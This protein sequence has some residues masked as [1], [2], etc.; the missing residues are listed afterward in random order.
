VVLSTQTEFI[1]SLFVLLAIALLAG[2]VAM[3]LGQVALVGQLIAGVVLGPY[4][5]GPFYGITIQGGVSPSLTAIQFL[6]TFFILFMAGMEMDPADIYHM[7]RRTLLTGLAVFLI[8]FGSCF[9][10]GYYVFPGMSILLLLFVSV[11]LSIT[12]LPVMGIMIAEFGLVGQRLGRMAMTVALVNELAAITV[13]A[14]LLQ[15]DNGG[16]H[17][18]VTSLAI[19]LGSVLL[20]L[21]VVLAAHQL[22]AALHQVKAWESFT[23]RASTGVR[24][25][26]AGFALLMVLAMGAA[27][28][29]QAL[30]LTFVIGAFYAGILVTP[31]SIG[32]ESYKTIKSILNVVCWGLFIPLF[33]AITGLQVNLTVFLSVAG[34][35]TILV[36]LA[37]AAGS[38]IGAGTIGAKSE[39]FS[40]PDAVA[41]GFMVNS[42]G[43]VEIAMAVILRGDGILNSQMFTLVVAVGMATTILAPIGAMRS[44]M[45][46]TKSR[47]ELVRRLPNL[48][49]KRATASRLPSLPVEEH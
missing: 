30:G 28:L 26:E 18:T 4:L 39:G 19:A 9:A 33:F 13:F 23:T 10:I 43:A 20:F 5:L 3:R 37:V 21:V 36:L 34:L 15:V 8:P 32:P 16:G 47:E 12:A 25:R 29:S 24:Y 11:V 40:T 44:W 14:L 1:V 46:T 38:K 31:A 42:R 17:P 35:G 45:S 48:A 2:E 49:P 22:L 7:K 27:L 6:A 41:F